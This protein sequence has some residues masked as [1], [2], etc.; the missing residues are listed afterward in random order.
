MSAY[1]RKGNDAI[2]S[3]HA[4]VAVAR[5]IGDDPTSVTQLIRI[6][7]AVLRNERPYLANYLSAKPTRS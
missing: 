1:D 3:A 6:A 4:I 5:G 2:D 7:C